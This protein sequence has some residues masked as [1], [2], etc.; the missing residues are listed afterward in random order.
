[1]STPQ[2]SKL[3]ETTVSEILNVLSA[4]GVFRTD[5]EDV[6]Q[7]LVCI[8][9]KIKDEYSNDLVLPWLASE[10]DIS[11]YLL[12]KKLRLGTVPNL[13][14]I[15]ISMNSSQCVN[16]MLPSNH[17]VKLVPDYSTGDDVIRD[18]ITCRI[19]NHVFP[20]SPHFLEYYDAGFMPILLNHR[21]IQYNKIVDLNSCMES[22]YYDKVTIDSTKFNVDT[23]KD[24]SG[25]APPYQ[26]PKTKENGYY[27]SQNGFSVQG[28]GVR[29]VVYC[30]ALA[31]KPI[32]L[33]PL[34]KCLKDEQDSFLQHLFTDPNQGLHGMMQ[35]MYHLGKNYGFV[36]NDAHS[37]NVVYDLANKTFVLLD[38]G[39]VVMTS[40]EYTKPN[41]TNPKK[42]QKIAKSEAVKFC[43]D[44]SFYTGNDFIDVF[45]DSKWLFLQPGFQKGKVGKTNTA[46]YLQVMNDIATISWN[47]WK[48]L[49][50]FNKAGIFNGAILENIKLFFEI[51]STT[52]KI[53]FNNYAYLLNVI[54]SQAPSNIRAIAAGLLWLA[55][56]LRAVFPN[57][58]TN[59]NE[60]SINYNDVCGTSPNAPLWAHGQ[61]LP[62]IYY[63]V[64]GSQPDF[65]GLYFVYGSV[66]SQKFTIDIL[67]HVF[68]PQPQQQS[69]GA[70]TSLRLKM[71]GGV[72]IENNELPI[73]AGIYLVH[74]VAKNLKPC[75]DT[76]MNEFS[77]VQ[78]FNVTEET[79]NKY[80]KI[81]NTVKLQDVIERN[82]NGNYTINKE[83]FENKL[84]DILKQ[85]E[86][87]QKPLQVQVP[88]DA[89]EEFAP[90]TPGQMTPERPH[91][92][93]RQS[94]TG[95]ATPETLEKTT[96]MKA[97]MVT[98]TENSIEYN[99]FQHDSGFVE[100]ANDEIFKID[101]KIDVKPFMPKYVP[102]TPQEI[103]NQFTGNMSI[104][105]S[106]HDH[107]FNL[108]GLP[109]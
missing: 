109:M 105:R 98:F 84:V 68:D 54:Y 71:K 45:D 55:L 103:M 42:Y 93:P 75:F 90:Q 26:S 65:A 74:L 88:E 72:V 49:Q 27:A 25:S 37:E 102:S 36:H 8:M 32:Q 53:N 22:Y 23:F 91:V 10:K 34:S 29:G 56:Y 12:L 20:N 46:K 28:D 89:N 5:E 81:A 16:A 17:F 106:F 99:G 83:K 14:D 30:N 47:I 43:K 4:N 52:V 41:T 9:K 64:L 15:P 95:A 76:V 96:N 97:I 7:K 85:L 57:N 3:Q 33:M 60:Y 80:S 61:V 92:F 1:M 39:R 19:I 108:L 104:P 67:D 73:D 2:Q 40:D 107:H 69:G 87:Q 11:C 24:C 62:M 31:F 44:S 66:K 82:N 100:K 70:R 101:D 48:D 50:N 38:Y 51:T 94:E 79:R 86:S 18:A 35:Q 6:E 13:I 58:Q 63:N 78:S 21:V 59:T 77:T